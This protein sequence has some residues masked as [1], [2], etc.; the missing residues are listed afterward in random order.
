ML[1]AGF[2]LLTISLMLLLYAC[3]SHVAGRAFTRVS[4]QKQFKTKV[5]LVLAAWLAYISILSLKGVF[6]NASLPPRIPLL[7]VLPAFLFFI[8]FFTNIK[9]KKIID[10]VPAAMPIYSQSF[11]IVVE[12]LIFGLFLEGLLP[13]AATF[14]GYN[15]DI[16]IGITAPLLAFFMLAKGKSNNWIVLAWNFAGL[17]TLLIVVSILLSSAYFPALWNQTE[18]ILPKGLGIFPYTFLAGLFMPLAVFM[19]LLSII[20]TR[21]SMR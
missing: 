10:A 20:K 12:L 19:H 18:S 2:I 7:L 16:V 21:K 8:Y 6:T 15:Y 1:K 11:R 9:F 13:K 4:E 17:T 14:E 5:A 3:A